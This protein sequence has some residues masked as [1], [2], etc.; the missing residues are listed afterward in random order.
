MNIGFQCQIERDSIAPNGKRITTFIIKFPRIILAEVNTHRMVAKNSSSN[1]AIPTKRIVDAMFADPFIPQTVYKNRP[2][3]Q[4]MELL[5][6]AEQKAWEEQ[7]RLRMQDTIIWVR[8]M[9]DRFNIHK[10][11]L[12]RYLEAWQWCTQITT[13]TDWDNLFALRT[14]KDAQPEFQQIAS[15]MWEAY[16][17]STPTLLKY[18][19]WHLPMTDGLT[20]QEVSDYLFAQGIIDARTNS[21]DVAVAVRNEMLRVSAGRCAA[22]S[23]LNHDNQERQTVEAVLERFQKLFGSFPIHASPAEHQATPH[24]DPEYVSG[25]LRGWRQFRKELPNE[26]ITDFTGW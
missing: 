2:G 20:Q 25:N 13:A 21:V 12:N 24:S 15:M 6:P 10:Q 7:C 9:E 16:Q 11:T 1:R 8:E 19:Q 23:Y 5:S 14:H 17:A 26:T 18:G 3:M 4:G 22:V